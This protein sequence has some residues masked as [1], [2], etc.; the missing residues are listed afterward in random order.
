MAS[1]YGV[2]RY[3]L[4]FAYLGLVTKRLIFVAN[5]PNN[6]IPKTAQSH[7]TQQTATS[8]KLLRLL[9]IANSCIGLYRQALGDAAL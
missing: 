2:V 1:S 7:E 4:T 9:R 5:T 8:W 6:L 3:L